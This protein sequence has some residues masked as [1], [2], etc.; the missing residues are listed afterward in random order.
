MRYTVVTL[1]INKLGILLI[2][3]NEAEITFLHFHQNRI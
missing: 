1:L 3:S 2:E